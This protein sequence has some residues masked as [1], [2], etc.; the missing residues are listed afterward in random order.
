MSKAYGLEQLSNKPHEKRNGRFLAFLTIG[1]V[2][3]L[4]V[5]QL[6]MERAG[7]DIAVDWPYLSKDKWSLQ[8]IRF[9]IDITSRQ[10]C[11]RTFPSQEDR[12]M[13]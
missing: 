12:S 2:H 3:K 11:F 4:K 5:A 6:V 7:I 1:L 13:T 10:T 8:V 9:V